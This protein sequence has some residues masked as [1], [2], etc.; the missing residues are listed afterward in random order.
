[1]KSKLLFPI[2]ILSAVLMGCKKDNKDEPTSVIRG[3]IKFDNKALG[4]RSNGVQLELWQYG[5][6]LFSKI[7]VYLDQDG[8][9]SASVF[10]GNY[11]LTLLRGNGPWADKTDSIDVKVSGTADVDVTVDP[12]FIIKNEKYERSG[13]TITATLNLQRVNTSKALELV[14][15]YI[16]QTLLTDQNINIANAQKAAAAIPD[17]NQPVTV[18]VTVPASF[19][20]EYAFMRVGVKAVGVAEL[21]YS[22]PQMIS[23]K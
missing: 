1:M 22:Q 10:N 6:Q 7:P 19:T 18:T 3:S 11:K 13:S 14:R 17:I 12:Y 8:T 15:V 9:F 21:L 16:G 4:V 5:Y 2:L 20:K 23:L